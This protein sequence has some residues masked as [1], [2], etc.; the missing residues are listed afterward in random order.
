MDFG[1]GRAAPFA[2]RRDHLE[3]DDAF[4]TEDN[5]DAAIRR[6]RIERKQHRVRGSEPVLVGIDDLRVVRRAEFLL[7]FGRDHD[8]DRQ[9]AVYGDDRLERVE[10]C[11]LGPFLVRG[12][13]RHQHLAELV[14][15]DLGRKR[16]TVP[17]LGL[18]GLHVVHH[19]YDQCLVG[20]R[21]VVTP[22]AGM[23]V[24]RYDLRLGKAEILEV[25]SHQFRH[26]GDADVLRRDRGLAQP[27][28]NRGQV[29]I[30]VGIDIVVYGLVLFQVRRNL[31][32]VISLVRR[33][34]ELRSRYGGVVIHRFRHGLAGDAGEEKQRE[35]DSFHVFVLR[36]RLA[37]RSRTLAVSV[38]VAAAGFGSMVSSAFWNNKNGRPIGPHQCPEDRP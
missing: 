16:R 29:V 14:I 12:P 8:V 4:H 27:A 13:A 1:R 5:A 23:A 28:L 9:R 21:I 36:A 31:A 34:R 2:P 26:L 15:D 32:E 22:Y 25:L 17:V 6:L 7:A 19:V 35:T 24:R 37:G 10:E 11:A 30:D 33:Q 3:I 18:D 38:I 20:P